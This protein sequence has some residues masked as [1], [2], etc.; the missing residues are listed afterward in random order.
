MTETQEAI[1]S[2]FALVGSFSSSTATAAWPWPPTPLSLTSP[3]RSTP[4]PTRC[5]T[6]S[7][8]SRCRRGDPRAGRVLQ[9]ALPQ[10][11][12][13]RGHR[14]GRGIGQDPDGPAIRRHEELG[15]QDRLR[16]L[17]QPPAVRL[18][19]RRHRHE[20]RRCERGFPDRRH[21]QDAAIFVQNAATQN[22]HPGLIFSGGPVYADQ[23]ISHA[24]GPAAVNG[25]QIG[26][27]FAL[28]LDRTPRPCRR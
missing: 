10:G 5:P 17:R 28:Y 4:A 13:G 12:D 7:A 14:L 1:I 19:D 20:E 27:V 24:G 25:I 9:E 3:S 11:H 26:Q 2:D 6:T 16:R 8:S 18:H 22:W 15:L 21:W 23:F